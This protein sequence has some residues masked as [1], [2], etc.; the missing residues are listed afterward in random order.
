MIDMRRVLLTSIILSLGTAL[1]AQ[2]PTYTQTVTG[3]TTTVTILEKSSGA[4]ID[5][6]IY[7]Q[8]LEDC[9]DAVVYGGVCDEK[10]NENPQVIEQL[11]PLRIPVMRWPAGTAIYDYEWKKGI[12]PK[13][14]RGAVDELVW[15]GKEYYTFGTDEFI[16]WCGKIGAEPYI[17]ISMGNNS[18]IPAS[19]GE[20]VDWVEYVN[21]PATSQ[22]GAWRA[23]NGHPEP[24]NV[25][26]WCIGNEN[27]LT[28]RDIHKKESAGEYADL[29][30]L[31]AKTLKTVCPDLS[32]LGVGYNAPWN[33]VV[34]DKCGD[35]LDFLTL[36][37]YMTAKIKD[38]NIVEPWKTLFGPVRFEESLKKNI[39]L[40][41]EYNAK[42]GRQANPLRYSI[43]EWNNRHSVFSDDKYSFTR[44]DDRRQFDVA[45]TA[46]MLNVFL[47]NCP[48]VGMAN[49]IFPV[50]GHGLLK[51]VG[52]DDA[53]KS[54]N[55]H[56]FDLYRANMTGCVLGVKVEG[57]GMTGIRL[58][59]L[60][61]DGEHDMDPE[62]LL[63]LCYI[64]CAAVAAED[65]SLNIAL[66]NRSYDRP[67]KVKVELPEGYSVAE[68][69]GIQS[70]D[71]K[72]ANSA[73]SREVV[74]PAPVQV[75]KNTLTL[76]PC[77]MVIVKCRPVQN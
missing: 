64:D 46:G 8:M 16:Q 12:G 3:K 55:Y 20:A 31:W 24:Y 66:S 29:L 69:V 67:Q 7:G 9:N 4:K 53:Y 75:K 22:M 6:M 17:N 61:M 14:K 42:S 71:V 74:K 33:K 47:R 40:L 41:K 15:G 32:L 70:G 30:I 57:P 39:A 34:L 49:Y 62:T 36:H 10:G 68:A 28:A 76:S 21:G 72:A 58:G 26:F 77:G 43:D 5:P 65:G 51:T 59:D 60:R 63:D 48:Y 73:A 56:V 19:L 2:D 1:A 50:N 45:G 38:N 13:E 52:N 27:Y 25:K 18:L 11:K 37:Y 54:A 35:E 23:A 44:K